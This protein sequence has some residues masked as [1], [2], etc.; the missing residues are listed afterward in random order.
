MKE[1]TDRKQ[2]IIIILLVVIILILVGPFLLLSLVYSSSMYQMRKNPLPT[3]TTGDAVLDKDLALVSSAK[4]MALYHM[5]GFDIGWTFDPETRVAEI[6][7]IR[8]DYAGYYVEN[9]KDSPDAYLDD[10]NNS[11][12]R[13]TA[14]QKRIQEYFSRQ[15]NDDITVVVNIL[16]YDDR[17]TPYLTVANG[18]VGYDAVNGIDLRGGGG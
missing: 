6:N 5:P 8:S 13:A 10:W 9:A 4:D 18:I 17:K 12:A 7:A 1:K 11:V 2:N 15:E 3:Q 14:A 16:D